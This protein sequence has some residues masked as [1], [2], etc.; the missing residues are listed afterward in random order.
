MWGSVTSLGGP[1]GLYRLLGEAVQPITMA[2][3]ALFGYGLP[4]LWSYHWGFIPLTASAIA[5]SL[6]GGWRH[7]N[8][9][10][11]IKE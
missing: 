10:N 1:G 4:F 5:L 9:T 6:L 11:T 2:T 7:L 3:G 8:D